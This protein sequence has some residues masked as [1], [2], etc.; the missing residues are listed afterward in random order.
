MNR[1]VIGALERLPSFELESHADFCTA[2][3]SWMFAK[4]TPAMTAQIARVLSRQGLCA[5]TPMPERRMT[6][7]LGK[8]PLIALHTRCSMSVQQMLWRGL[9]AEFGD[10]ANGHLAALDTALLEE[11]DLLELDPALPVPDYAKHEIHQQPGGYVG[12]EAAGFIY[13]HGTNSFYCGT[14]DND[15]IHRLLAANASAPKDEEVTRIVDVGC[16]IGQ[17]TQWLGDRFPNAQTIGIDV[18]APML[19][20]AHRR[21]VQ[22]QRPIL[23]RQALAEATGLPTG[24]ID[25]VTSYLLFHEVPHDAARAIVA[26]AFRIL[27]PGGVFQVFDFKA[28]NG[29][30]P[31]AIQY[32]REID[33][34]INQEVWSNDYHSHD[35][36]GVLR[37]AGF[38][39]EDMGA[40]HGI[41]YGYCATKPRD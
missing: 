37:E 14:N 1:G 41:V 18:S 5:D 20:Y 38:N 30:V 26:E 9:N 23:Y 40:Q 28:N 32:A 27:R 15:E 4:T 6:E 21:A 29:V 35:F 36:Q 12:N 19:R 3:R 31:P 16:G 24:S 33:Q 22:L 13:H 10:P 17:L 34:T 8:D 39:V 11:P 25:L 7:L 2:F